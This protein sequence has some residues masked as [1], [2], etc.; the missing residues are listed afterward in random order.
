MSTVEL[1]EEQEQALGEHGI[2]QGRAFVLMRPAA[3]R[4]LLGIGSDEELRRELQ[5]AFD[6]ADRGELAEWDVEEFLQQMHSNS[7]EEA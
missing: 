4:D 1:T 7:R 3:F 6:Q 2:V 5:M